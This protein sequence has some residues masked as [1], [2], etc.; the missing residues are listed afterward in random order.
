MPDAAGEQ[1]RDGATC[2]SKVAVAKKEDKPPEPT[3]VKTIEPPPKPVVK[4]TPPPPPPVVKPVPVEK[5]PVVVA[6]NEPPQPLV[7]AFDDYLAG[8]YADV[9][10][11]NVDSYAD[12]HARFH[13]YLVRAAAKFTLG[14]IGGENSLLDAARAY[15][16]AA[17]AIDGSTSPDASVFSPLFRRFYDE[18]HHQNPLQLL[19]LKKKD[20][21]QDYTKLSDG[22]E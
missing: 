18:A 20:I 10:R 12:T 19:K 3:P 2:A 16:R 11:I 15:A 4:A 6:K 5:P 1:Q 17:K 9:A 7:Q 21:H 13:A 14:T 22:T 8:R